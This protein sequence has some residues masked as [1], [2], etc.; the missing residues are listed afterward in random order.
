MKTESGHVHCIGNAIFAFNAISI[1]LKL[2]GA[3]ALSLILDAFGVEPSWSR[4]TD[5]DV[6]REM[7]CDPT[8]KASR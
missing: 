3:S 8:E 7:F 5:T 6:E 2:I 1:A 4:A